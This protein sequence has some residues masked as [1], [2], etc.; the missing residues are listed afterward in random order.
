MPHLNTDRARREIALSVAVTA[1]AALAFTYLIAVRTPLGQQFDTRV[2]LDV[3]A[4]LANQTWTSTLLTLV[5]PVPVLAAVAGL[6]LI[7]GISRGARTG[8]AVIAVA[9]GTVAGATVLKAVLIRPQ[10]LSDAVNSL[11]SGHVAA[12]AGLFVAATLAVTPRYRL[13]VAMLGAAGISLTGLATL[14]LQWHRPSDVLAATLVAV[15]VGAVVQA[16][17][18]SLA[19]SS[20]APSSRAA[21]SRAAGSQVTRGYGHS[22]GPTPRLKTSTTP[23]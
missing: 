15:M 16:A 12:V 4:A 17:P 23:R 19:P 20:R 18:S 7:A 22:S 11:P 2:M 6:A 1:A 8:F 13:S 3:S 9:A 5:S 21:G 10:Y 14:A